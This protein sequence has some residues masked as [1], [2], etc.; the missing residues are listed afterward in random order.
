M[1]VCVCVSWADFTEKLTLCFEKTKS[2]QITS[3][4]LN[5]YSCCIGYRN[6]WNQA[7][8]RTLVVS[9]ERR[10]SDKV[11]KDTQDKTKQRMP[12]KAASSTNLLSR[13]PSLEGWVGSCSSFITYCFFYKH[14]SFSNTPILFGLFVGPFFWQPYK[15]FMLPW[16]KLAWIVQTRLGCMSSANL[17]VIIT[18]LSTELLAFWNVLLDV[19]VELLSKL[20]GAF[21]Y[22]ALFKNF[23]FPPKTL[24]GNAGFQLKPL[25]EKPIC[26]FIVYKRIHRSIVKICYVH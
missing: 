13:S 11:V 14:E 4:A 23:F 24:T 15:C 21:W 17:W 8:L 12:K 1:C 26:L 25:Y 16:K 20:C 18:F 3:N 7:S 6:V 22:C 9:R 5:P 10:N 19:V 2:F